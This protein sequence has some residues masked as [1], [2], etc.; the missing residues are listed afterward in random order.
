L[1]ASPNNYNA[2]L[3]N[4]TATLNGAGNGFVL[5]GNT[6]WSFPNIGSQANWSISVWFKRTGPSG[7]AGCLVTEYFD[8]GPINI[9]ILSADSGV[10]AEQFACG[11]YN[12]GFNLGTPITFPLN[13]WHQMTTTWDGTNIKTYY[14]SVLNSTVDK[15][16]AI[17]LSS[18]NPYRI[19]RR[20]D[21]A[22][23]VRGEIGE[24]LIYSAPL[25]P[26]QIAAHYASTS[27]TYI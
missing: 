8:G 11:F 14:D 16:G 5:D 7:E 26:A 27:P 9:A 17:S 12:S 22:N 4:G 19:G 20:W 25:S 24:V 3:E 23:Y 13:E 1:D 2:T 18:I 21:N 6:Y 15:S 10:G